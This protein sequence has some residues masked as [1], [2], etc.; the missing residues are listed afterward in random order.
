[1]VNKRFVIFLLISLF[2]IN[3]VKAQNNAGYGNLLWGSTP[4]DLLRE[5]PQSV[6]IYRDNRSLQENSFFN[7]QYRIFTNY[8]F[9][10]YENR[11]IVIYS[12]FDV[13]GSYG[14]ATKTCRYFFYYNN[15]LFKVWYLL[16][17]IRQPRLNEILNILV[18]NYGQYNDSLINNN[19]FS[20][21]NF[22]F[23]T[24]NSNLKIEYY[25]DSYTGSILYINPR[26]D[27]NFTEGR[28]NRNSF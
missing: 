24:S 4:E 8:N 26:I 23:W 20:N 19:T 10:K 27:S 21:E 28:I 18:E 13:G 3:C 14:I 12:E 11:N 16:P 25:V 22:Y 1:M 2:L 5:Y 9:I 15:Q 7:E 17:Q 6:I